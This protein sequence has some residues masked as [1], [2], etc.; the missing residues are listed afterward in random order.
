MRVTV[1]EAA[2]ALGVSSQFIRIGLQRKTL[3]IGTA[4]KMKRW[5][6]YINPH[7]LEMYLGTKKPPVTATTDGKTADDESAER[8]W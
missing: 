2:K 7:Q 3:P 5:V 8:T 4:V 1:S 6:Y